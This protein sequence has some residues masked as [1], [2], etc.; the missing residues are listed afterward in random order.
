MYNHLTTDLLI[1]NNNIII[2]ESIAVATI[3]LPSEIDRRD[4]GLEAAPR[5]LRG[6]GI[7]D[8]RLDSE[9]GNH[10][11]VQPR[12]DGPVAA[13]VVLEALPFPGRQVLGGGDAL[14]REI[15]ERSI[16][17][18]PVVH[19]DLALAS[20]PQMLLCALGGIRHCDEGDVGVSEGLGR[21]P[22]R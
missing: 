16:V 8:A 15:G 18:F 20:D 11:A 4:L 9:A 17:A 21:F 22:V 1:A 10:V 3:R 2:P 6:I 19:E 5:P 12:L 14:G 7:A 13:N